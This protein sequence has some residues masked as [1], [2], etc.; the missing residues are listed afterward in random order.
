VRVTLDVKGDDQTP[1]AGVVVY[2]T[3]WAPDV[4][5]AVSDNLGH[6][7]AYVLPGPIQPL[8]VRIPAPYFRPR[9]Y[10]DFEII[11]DGS[12]PKALKPLKL[13]RGKVLRGR[14]IDEDMRPVAGAEIAGIATVPS[15]DVQPTRAVSDQQGEFSIDG[16][17]A[18]TATQLW[19]GK[20]EAITGG[21]VIAQPGGE[22]VTLTIRRNESVAL[23]GRVVDAA[24]EPLAGAWVRIWSQ[25]NRA[26]ARPGFQNLGSLVF[27]GSDRL[28]TDAQ[29]RFHT[30]QSLRPDLRYSLEV[31]APGMLALDTETIE[32]AVWH[33]TR[34]ADV[35][36][37]Q[38]PRLRVITGR[39]IDSQKRAISGAL[40]WQ[41]GDGPRRTETTAD[42]DG[43]F[44]LGGIYDGPAFLFVR[45]EGFRLQGYPIAHDDKSC[46]V[47]IHR[48]NEPSRILRTLPPSLTNE[49]RREMIVS[50]L[51]PWLPA[52]REPG[53]HR[54]HSIAM[55]TIGYCD[56]PRALEM[57]GNGAIAEK[58]QPIA[59]YAA[60]RGLLETDFEAALET[61][62]R[63]QPYAQVEFCLRAWDVL[64]PERQEIR[65]KLLAESLVYAR[66]HQEP[67]ARARMIGQI[68]E[69][70][71]D[72]GE[73]ERGT[74]LLREAQA[75]AEAVPGPASG[76]PLTQAAHDRA[77]F[78]SSLARIDRP[79]ALA[80]VEGLPENSMRDEYRAGVARG[81][82]DHDAT[83]AQRLVEEIAW[84]WTRFHAG[85]PAL[86]RMAATDC[87][88]AA[89]V[90]RRYP[91]RSQR[92]YALGV[93]AHGLAVTDRS[94]AA[95]LIEEAYGI[96]EQAHE[97]RQ[98]ENRNYDR[99]VTAAALLPVVEAI[100]ASALEAH[101]WRTV[102]LR[103]P[104]AARAGATWVE[105]T[106]LAQFA[107]LVARYDTA[108]AGDLLDPLN[109][110]WRELAAEIEPDYRVP[111][112]CFMVST[113]INPH[114]AVELVQELPD[115]PL[116]PTQSPKLIAALKVAEWLSLPTNELWPAVYI[117]CGLRDPNVRDAAWRTTE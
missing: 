63:V 85:L 68:A 70:W 14:V 56:P 114:W 10:G 50:L 42:E 33:A 23:E 57:A 61:I 89:E 81:L 19:A 77:Q 24:G 116:P 44:Q 53:F 83:E 79:A 52:L 11:A 58:Y 65:N 51:E 88:R 40:V 107:A 92:A 18:D 110:R 1:V 75:L 64:G 98:T 47:T 48:L 31:E 105:E 35:V 62:A 72:V 104:R 101:L 49:E 36:L 38:S 71:I 91:E 41:S 7:T 46:E 66:A 12:E 25:H 39:V 95:R 37:R 29:G 112:S 97:L 90:A 78:A 80:L 67:G 5:R 69:R 17:A 117:D 15:G 9:Q 3:S 94:A 16:L 2:L 99:S 60:A 21:P 6:I 113:I 22:P 106:R 111:K 54:E 87:Q 34:F 86:H 27:D 8:A 108:I 43:H 82:A 32:P 55:R 96:L 4:T 73:Q 93:I 102:A 20:D 45:K 84:D 100:D 115:A 109:G 13:V 26:T 30:P 28:V 74:A 76:A 59:Y 103:A